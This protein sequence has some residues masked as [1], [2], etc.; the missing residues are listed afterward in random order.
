MLLVKFFAESDSDSINSYSDYIINICKNLNDSG[1]IAT[2]DNTFGTE[3]ENSIIETE[4]NNI[5]LWN[6]KYTEK[7]MCWDFSLL[8]EFGTYS[9][10]TQFTVEIHSSNYTPTPN[11]KYLEQLKLK[12]KNAIKNDWQKL[13]WLIDEDAA[14]LPVALYPKIYSVENLARQLI[15]ELMTKKY[16]TTWWERFVPIQIKE[17]HRRRYAGYKKSVTSFSN[18]DE[19]LLSIDISDLQK[20]FTF[21]SKKWEPVPDLEMDCYLSDLTIL[22]SDNIINK[23]KAQSKIDLDLWAIHFSHYLPSDFLERFDDFSKDRNH[24]AHNKLLDRNI[25]GKILSNA[26]QLESDLKKAI[27]KVANIVVSKEQKEIIER[28]VY[29]MELEALAHERK[30]MEEQTNVSIRE[31]S[32]IIDLLNI[33][34]YEKYSIISN[35][36]RFREDI[37]VS[38]FL[39]IEEKEYRGTLFEITY[40]ITEETVAVEYSFESIND[41]TGGETR[42]RININNEFST[43][44]SYLNGDAEF[45]VELGYYVPLKQDEIIDNVDIAKSILEYIESNFE[46]LREKVD[47]DMYYLIKNGGSSPILELECSE[48]GEPYICVNEDYASYGTC[49]NCGAYNEIVKCDRCETYFEGSCTDDVNLCDNCKEYLEQQ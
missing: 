36:I 5:W 23:I 17:K 15:N 8:F 14:V 29:Q 7:D 38:D 24:V 18:I 4:E 27:E 49:L 22:T 11:N 12:I 16:G 1:L 42:L 48:C 9:C 43:E 21:C 35:E 26:N 46:N 37:E 6:F 40:K 39:D 47:A 44:V 30:I 34:L 10:S 32:E 19:R 20:I 3:I 31:Q 2:Y 28:E 13:I 45:D 41:E 25:Y 33:F